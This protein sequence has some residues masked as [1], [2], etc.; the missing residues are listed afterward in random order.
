MDVGNTYWKEQEVLLPLCR[1]IETDLRLH[2][3]SA[4]L[5]GTINVNP[6]KVFLYIFISD[7]FYSSES[8]KKHKSAAKEIGNGWPYTEEKYFALS[9]EASLPLLMWIPLIEY[10]LFADRGS[11][12]VM[13]C[14]CEASAIGNKVYPHKESCGDISQRCF[15]QPY[16]S[17]S[18]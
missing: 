13:V 1:D 5:K 11:G 16:C 10:V 17:G 6:T 12:L 14:A 3:H 2:V 4:H 15:L 9:I 18:A 7:A 8:H